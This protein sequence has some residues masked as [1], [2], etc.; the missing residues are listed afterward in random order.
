MI[1]DE[2][3]AIEKKSDKIKYRTKYKCTKYKFITTNKQDMRLHSLTH[4]N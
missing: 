4:Q 1:D 3:I 2:S